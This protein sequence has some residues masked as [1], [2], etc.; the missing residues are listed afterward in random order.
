MK[1]RFSAIFFLL[2]YRIFVLPKIYLVDFLAV[3]K[4]AGEN[5]ITL[6]NDF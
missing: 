6:F 3:L 1:N 5:L 2:A 4:K